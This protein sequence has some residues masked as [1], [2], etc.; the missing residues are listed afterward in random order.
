M[1]LVHVSSTE[2]STTFS[3]RHQTKP[4]LAVLDI[5]KILNPID[6]ELP[7]HH[8]WYYLNRIKIPS[9]FTPQNASI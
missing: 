6:F 4:R 5:S 3:I 9:A 7:T 8:S 2:L 1:N